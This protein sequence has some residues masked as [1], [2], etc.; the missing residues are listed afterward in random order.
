[1]SEPR[2]LRSVRCGG[3]ACLALF[4]VVAALL[5]A[6]PARA[7][8][9]P[10]GVHI[11]V[12]KGVEERTEGRCGEPRGISLFAFPDRPAEGG[13][14]RWVAVSETPREA[15]LVVSDDSGGRIASSDQRRGGP[16]YSWMV[17][18][19]FARYGSYH[20]R[21]SIAG[22]AA[23]CAGVDVEAEGPP[24]R[25]R[26]S[27]SLWPIERAWDRDTEN[28]YSAWIEKL[29]ADPLDASPSWKSLHVLTRDS[30]RNFLHD[31][32]GLGEDSEGG[33]TLQPDCADL[34]YFL[35]AYFSWKLRLPF[36]Y[37]RCYSMAQ[38][39]APVCSDTKSNLEAAPSG[40]ETLSVLQRF[41]ARSVADSAHSATGRTA[42]ID[43]R[44]DV[45]PVRISADTLRPGTVY[46]DPY[47]HVLIVA[48]RVDQTRTAGGILLAVDAQPDG[49][50]AR[51]RYWR[52]NFLFAL[53][54]DGSAPGFKRFR[55]VV[56]AGDSVRTLDNNEILSHPGYG[57]FSL[58][59]YE[60]SA[61]DFYD[62]VDAALS[63]AKRSAR[64]VLLEVVDSLEEQVEQRVA[65]VQGGEDYLA[66]SPG[67]V[68]MP[69]GAAI[70]QTVGAWEDYATPS[71][72]L[73]LLIAIDVVRGFPEMVLR[74]P[75][76]FLA[77]RG[78]SPSGLRAELQGM[79]ENELER[80]T[81]QYQRSDG[82]PWTLPL[83]E[84]IPRADELEMAY[85]PN[86]CV[87]TRWGA[88]AESIEAMTCRRRAPADQQ[89]LMGELRDWF[90]TR[91]RPAT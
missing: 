18:V 60:G 71:R 41:F 90:H 25:P 5:W 36:M 27:S 21:L 86:D 22:D 75:N 13:P 45:Y 78:R 69:S 66:R 30:E 81:F 61:D 74:R 19:P 57:D 77:E 52:G 12:P 7:A 88:P 89:R 72:D 63:P 16:P 32:L 46:I 48:R 50:V 84:L 85:N 20:A 3:A 82:T 10:F 34:P 11:R 44:T 24:P 80:R 64:Q 37:S 39:Q 67:T 54:E 49:T 8:D 65:S 14:I 58:I 87:E 28:L 91:T 59:Q 51:K 42:A 4:A 56:M 38:G 79:L 70:F 40:R 76:R 53:G 23:A 1:M 6:R 47:G 83:S 2:F 35:R 43:D 33:I 62:R 68:G 55:P 31:S 17:E 73:R 15:R 9:Q 26:T 29:F